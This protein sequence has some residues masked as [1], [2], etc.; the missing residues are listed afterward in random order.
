MRG[1]APRVLPAVRTTAELAATV[2][3]ATADAR[4]NHSVANAAPLQLPVA[5]L[6]V[7]PYTLGVWL[8]DGT[9]AAAQYTSADPE[10]A[11]YIEAR[12]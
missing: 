5:D 3:C 7:P 11:M 6:P 8:G 9:S 2:R 12:A 10:I 4:L 1:D